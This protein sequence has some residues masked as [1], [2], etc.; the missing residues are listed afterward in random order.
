MTLEVLFLLVCSLLRK[1]LGCF[2]VEKPMLHDR[3][4]RENVDFDANVEGS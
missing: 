1:E 4:T 3:L 2:P